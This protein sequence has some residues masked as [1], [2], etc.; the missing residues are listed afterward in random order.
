MESKELAKLIADY[1]LEKKAEDVVLLNLK[2]V[3]TITDYFIICSADSDVQVKAITDNIIGRLKEQKIKVWHTE[4][5]QS[6]K[7]VLLDLVDVVVHVFQPETRDFF[8]LEKLWGDA[9]ITKVEDL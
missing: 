7:W 5:Y 3:T 9:E 8:G 4:G 2:D 1:S 6:L